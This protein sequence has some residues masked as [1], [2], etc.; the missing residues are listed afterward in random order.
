MAKQKKQLTVSV[1]VTPED[2]EIRTKEEFLAFHELC[3]D[4]TQEYGNATDRIWVLH[5]I[6]DNPAIIAVVGNGP[7]ARENAYKLLCCWN[8][9]DKLV[10]A[11]K[12]AKQYFEMLEKAT[13]VEHGNLK[14][15]KAAGIWVAG[16]TDQA[17]NTLYQQDLTGPLALVMGGEG[18]GMRRLTTELCDY[19]VRIPMVGAIESLNVSVAAGVCLFEIQRQRQAR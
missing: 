16:A 4:K 12:N 8:T 14:E 11:C 9:H 5:T 13:G 2:T 17:T 18:S 1:A 6:E 7:N 3:W 10:E 19:L 15:L